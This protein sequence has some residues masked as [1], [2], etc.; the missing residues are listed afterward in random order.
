MLLQVDMIPP[1][2]DVPSE[3]GSQMD[4]NILIEQEA[5]QRNMDAARCNR[6]KERCEEM[7][8]HRADA[9]AVSLAIFRRE[10]AK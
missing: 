9:G 1:W 6:M 10:V 2:A 7:R 3:W 8:K 4:A 5:V